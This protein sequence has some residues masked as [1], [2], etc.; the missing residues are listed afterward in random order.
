MAAV[1]DTRE[2]ILEVSL[3]RF[4]VDGYRGTSVRDISDA[5]GV[6]QPALYYHFGNKD[7]ILAA[8][9]QPLLDDGEALLTELGGLRG[10]REE[11]L[12]QALAGYLDVVAG[13]LDLFRLVNYDPS[14]RSHPEAGHLLA[15][16]A[17]RFTAL[18]AGDKRARSQIQAAAALGAI[19]R[20]LRQ[21]GMK[22][23]RNRSQIL[24]C[25]LAAATATP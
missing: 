7:G 13:H 9:M 5:V 6:T 22:T 25:A 1:A 3:A 8:L 10:P 19:H 4:V 21:P 16:Q 12:E 24:A 15:A 20:V 23:G 17:A 14:V 18:V 11:I 2:R